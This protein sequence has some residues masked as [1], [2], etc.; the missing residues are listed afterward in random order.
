VRLIEGWTFRQVR[1]ALAAAPH[2]K[3]TTP[4]WTTPS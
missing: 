1:A 2:L 3:P 4:R